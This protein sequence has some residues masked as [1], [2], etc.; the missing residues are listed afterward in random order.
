MIWYQA[1][2]CAGTSGTAGWC[3]RSRSTKCSSEGAGPFHSPGNSA[4]QSLSERGAWLQPQQQMTEKG[5]WQRR[6]RE[7]MCSEHR[8]RGVLLPKR[9]WQPGHRH[10][11]C[12]LKAA[13]CRLSAPSQVLPRA[14]THAAH[15][16]LAETFSGLPWAF[17]SAPTDSPCRTSLENQHDQG[18]LQTGTVYRQLIVFPAAILPKSPPVEEQE[19]LTLIP[20]KRN[21]SNS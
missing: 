1:G 11:P 20:R 12:R 13:E 17:S 16:S 7:E 4:L 6:L 2:G 14:V 19:A 9:G 18:Q 15:Q 21:L 10:F 8:K 5:S 3:G